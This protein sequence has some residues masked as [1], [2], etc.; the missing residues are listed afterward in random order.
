MGNTKEQLLAS[1]TRGD[2]FTVYLVG[3][4]VHMSLTSAL[5][6]RTYSVRN[7]KCTT[8]SARAMTD[9]QLE[10]ALSL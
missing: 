7:Y 1:R 6:S 9:K 2:E 4:T 5:S 10:Q 8:L 3:K